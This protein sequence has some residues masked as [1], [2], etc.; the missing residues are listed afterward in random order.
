MD[1]LEKFIKENRNQ[2]DTL[3]PGDHLWEN[4]AGDDPKIR[5]INW[6]DV[7]MKIAAAVVIFIASYFFH[8]LINSDGK[9]EMAFDDKKEIIDEET[10]PKMNDLYEAEAYYTSQIDIAK[11]E[12]IDQ[13]DV[14]PEIKMELRNEFLELDSTYADLENDLKENV[15]NERVVEAMIQNYRIKLEILE[16]VLSQLKET[17]ENKNSKPKEYEI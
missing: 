15:G 7:A 4:I 1:K 11:Q 16:E 10:N 13:E 6:K 12:L 2:F 5:S 3:E 9:S 14:S 8:D 17:E